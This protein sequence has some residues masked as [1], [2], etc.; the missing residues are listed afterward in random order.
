M[1]NNLASYIDHTALK[2][3]TTASDIDKLCVEASSSEF[4]AVC[5]PPK[6]IAGAKRLLE[7]SNVKVATVISFPMGYNATHVKLKEIKDAILMGA[8]ELDMVID[9]CALKSGDWQH[10]EKEIELCL[11]P[12]RDANKVMKLI[13]ES[14]LLTNTELIACCEL[15]RQY[16]I[17]FMKTST[18]FS[19]A[20]ASVNAVQIM[21]QHLPENIGIKA[22]G[23]IRTY[24]F[25]KELIDA[26]ATRIGTSNSMQI[27][28]EFEEYEND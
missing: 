3:S 1:P 17:Q 20:G 2:Q 16:D 5:V 6:Y 11:Q 27:M 10:L 22:S 25:A 12:A 15:Y 26:G 9:L 14:G 23:G 21:R 28:K 24:A 7:N 18:G 4:M 19:E 13:V 8:D